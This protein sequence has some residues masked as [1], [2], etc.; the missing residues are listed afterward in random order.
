MTELLPPLIGNHRDAR[1]CQTEC[2]HGS[3]YVRDYGPE[4][5]EAEL[6]DFAR[7]SLAAKTRCM[8]FGSRT[9][10]TPAPPDH[11]EVEL[12]L[13][14]S[15]QP[16]PSVE[17]ERPKHIPPKPVWMAAARAFGSGTQDPRDIRLVRWYR[18]QRDSGQLPPDDD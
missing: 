18:Q 14:Q 4:W 12:T 9:W 11:V 5:T 7:R 3:V 6:V 1:T 13:Y 16:D 10:L 17:T 2:D 8:C 15:E